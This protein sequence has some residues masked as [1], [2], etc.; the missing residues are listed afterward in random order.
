MAKI[1]STII[2]Q[3]GMVV[4]NIEKSAKDWAELLGVPVPPIIVTDGMD[5]AQT[6][7]K[8]SPSHARARLAFFHLGPQVDLELIEPDSNPSTWRECLE[9][10]GEG[11]HHMAFNIKGMREQSVVLEG[12]GLECVQK[13]EYAG[14]RYAY[15]DAAANKFKVVFE[16]LEND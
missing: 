2:T 12:H 1:G 4:E 16:L 13:G 6:V 11:V 9:S 8:G 14:G 7:F 15:F 5:K 10:K 3:I